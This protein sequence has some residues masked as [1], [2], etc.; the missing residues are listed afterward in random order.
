MGAFS[1]FAERTR[2]RVGIANAVYVGVILAYVGGIAIP[3]WINYRAAEKVKAAAAA[4]QSTAPSAGTVVTPTNKGKKKKGPAVNKEFF[5]QLKQ[6]IKVYNR[7]YITNEK[8][9]AE[10]IYRLFFLA[11]LLEIITI[12]MP[13]IIQRGTGLY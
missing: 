8:M 11:V 6:M 4:G 1:K 2:E 10:V 7:P 12:L 9:L 13:F 5:R 3:R